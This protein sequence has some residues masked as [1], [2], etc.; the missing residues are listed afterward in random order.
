MG[1]ELQ[2]WALTEQH[3]CLTPRTR[4]VL[5][6][7]CM[8]SHD[9]HGE[10]WMRGKRLISEHLPDMSYSS[11]KNHLGILVRNELLTKLEHGGG[12]T[13]GGRGTSNRYRVNAPSV[14]PQ[15]PPQGVL[16][17]IIR[18]PA[19]SPPE[20]E[21]T[22]TPMTVDASA[23]HRKLDE[24]LSAGITP[25][26]VVA[27]LEFTAGTLLESSE[28]TGQDVETGQV[29]GETRQVE[30]ET[31]HDTGPVSDKQV[32]DHGQFDRNP[33]GFIT[34]LDEETGQV[35]EKQVMD[36]GRFDRNPTGFMTSAPIH[37]EK[38]GEDKEDHAAAANWTDPE[39]NRTG[40]GKDPPDFFDLLTLKLAAEGHR[41][42]RPAQFDHLRE[43]MPQYAEA[44]GGVLPDQRTAD[45]IVG[46]LRNSQG[47]RN[48][49]GF[50]L[51][52]T[53]DVLRTGEGFVAYEPPPPAPPPEHPAEPLPPPDWNTL[54]L[55][56]VEQVS[57]AQKVWDAV[58]DVLHGQVSSTAY[59]T[60][61][62]SSSGSA[63]ADG[64]FVVGTANSFTSEML[65]NRMHPLIESA[66]N[67]VTGVKLKIQYAVAPVEGRGECPVCQTGEA[68][69]E[70]S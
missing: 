56:H 44:T 31:G 63:Y 15:Q 61:L 38:R 58:L 6:A 32:T 27:I 36:H 62:S 12:R 18:S 50:V 70:A 55:A 30:G 66:V 48:V 5:A 68:R 65:R 22:D 35:D 54:H 39:S 25:A 19:A 67:G 4:L 33:T 23:A 2:R 13:S 21:V 10:F 41:G 17:E 9:D 52:V 51:S 49:V 40:S 46:R 34:C 1:Y 64:Q 47:V 11:Y 45:Y 28:N 24:M 43:L 16:P 8:V 7:I 29:K 20:P 26:Q 37:E 59:E 69:T 53:E 42:I 60:W 3:P 57:P 14:T